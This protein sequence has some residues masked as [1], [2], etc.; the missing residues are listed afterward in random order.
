MKTKVCRTNP[1]TTNKGM[2]AKVTSLYGKD[3]TESLYMLKNDYCHIPKS[4]CSHTS[5]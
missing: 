1:N 3:L 5:L 4:V 2:W